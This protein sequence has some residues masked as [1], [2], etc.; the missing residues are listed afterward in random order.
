MLDEEAA[1][2]QEAGSGEGQQTTPRTGAESVPSSHEVERGRTALIQWCRRALHPYYQYQKLRWQR[3]INQNHAEEDEEGETGDEQPKETPAKKEEEE[4]AVVLLDLPLIDGFGGC[5]SNGLALVALLHRHRLLWDYTFAGLRRRTPKENVE[6]AFKTAQEV[7]SLDVSYIDDP[8]AQI[9][10]GA[11]DEKKILRLV[12]SIYNKLNEERIRVSK[13]TSLHELRNEVIKLR[14]LNERLKFE[15]QFAKE[16]LEDTE[17]ETK[18]ARKE[19]R[20]EREMRCSLERRKG[21]SNRDQGP[22]SSED[23]VKELQKRLEQELN[24]KMELKN[25]L[26]AEMA[27][28]AMWEAK[29]TSYE[30]D[31]GVLGLVAMCLSREQ[32]SSSISS[33]TDEEESDSRRGSRVNSIGSGTPVGTPSPSVRELERD[34]RRLK[35]DLEDKERKVAHDAEVIKGLKELVDGKEKEAERLHR[36]MMNHR[37]SSQDLKRQLS[38][39][40]ELVASLQKEKKKLLRTTSQL[41]PQA[42]L[43]DAST[44]ADAQASASL[45]AASQ[46][47]GFF[48][49]GSSTPSELEQKLAESE[50]QRKKLETTLDDIKRE[51]MDKTLEVERLARNAGL[52]DNKV[53]RLNSKLSDSERERESMEK[54]LRTQK[55]QLESLQKTVTRLERQLASASAS[56]SSA[57][58]ASAASAT[59]PKVGKK[60]GRSM[61]SLGLGALSS[62]SSSSSSSGSGTLAALVSPRG[63]ETSAS[64]APQSS[65]SSTSPR[66]T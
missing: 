11:P 41:L 39:N 57:S 31:A 1:L 54:T 66:G 23:V 33:T 65:G 29:A 38:Q 3:K 58:A 24:E 46:I 28:S 9:L 18:Y 13:T 48:G 45:S 19:L 8:E 61:F 60:S 47:R 12:L 17:A 35:A 27:K 56:A 4:P 52:Q 7:L 30:K 49:F 64:L 62:S 25:Q 55:N 26:A 37:Q 2:A 43:A 44:E 32:R 34:L 53:N 16:Q 21:R 14:E 6:L 40:L 15:A 5:W 20:T 59:S 10:S 63:K 42:V 22:D 51:L 50:K 36:L